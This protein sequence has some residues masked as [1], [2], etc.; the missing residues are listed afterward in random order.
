MTSKSRL[1]DPGSILSICSSARGRLWRSCV[2]VQILGPV[3][4]MR[5][6]IA[7][8]VYNGTAMTRRAFY[9]YGLLGLP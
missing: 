3:E 7:E 2:Q 5:Y 1:H 4:F 6:A 8:N 9:P